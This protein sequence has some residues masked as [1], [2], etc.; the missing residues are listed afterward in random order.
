[1]TGISIESFPI[2]LGSKPP[3][4]LVSGVISKINKTLLPA[5][6]QEVNGAAQSHF[7]SIKVTRP[8]RQNL[9]TAAAV[10]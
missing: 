8:A 7:T 1:M 6:S 5:G 2:E 9:L 4:P 10:F 3:L